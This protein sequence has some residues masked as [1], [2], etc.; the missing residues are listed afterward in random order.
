VKAVTAA[1]AGLDRART[2]ASPY[3]AMQTELAGLEK[4]IPQ[5]QTRLDELDAARPAPATRQRTIN[6][7]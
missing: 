5:L 7:P 4:Q 2:A 1:T 3:N 6:V